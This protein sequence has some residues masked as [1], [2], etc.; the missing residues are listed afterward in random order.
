[1]VD[2]F[3]AAGDEA[4]LVRARAG[5]YPPPM[6]ELPAVPSPPF[7]IDRD[8]G[9]RA[10]YDAE[11]ILPTG[12]GGFAMGTGSGAP[13][14]KYHTLL[15]GA[16][17]PPVDRI[18]TIS[19]LHETVVLDTGTAR[20]RIVSLGAHV[21][22]GSEADDAAMP[23]LVRFEKERTTAR[24]T[25]EGRGVRLVKEL[26]VGWRRNVAAVRYRVTADRPGR[27][28]VTAWFAGR[29]FHDTRPTP[30]DH[31]LEFD[32]IPR[33]VEARGG[34][35]VVRAIADTARFDRRP[36]LAPL[37]CF[38]DLEH[39]RRLPD[40]DHLLAPGCFRLD[41]EAGKEATFTLAFALAPDEPDPALFDSDPRA[42][43]LGAL[44][45]RATRRDANLAGLEPL[46]GAADD[47]LVRRFV[48]DVPLMSVIAGYPWFADWGRD[49]MISLPGLMLTTGRF[50]DARS[51]LE[52]F[53]RHVSQGMI[54]NRFDDYGGPPHY[55]TVD[56]SLWF[57]HAATEYLGVTSDRAGFDRAMRAACIGIIEGYRRG[58]RY[59]IRMD[60][61]DGLIIAGDDT[62]QLTWMDAK[63]D[64][65]VFTPRHGKAVEINALWH[66][67][68]IAFAGA[69]GDSEAERAGEYRALA[70]RVGASFRERFVGGPGGGLHDCLRP[71]GAG[72]FVASGELRPNQIFAAS[73]EHSPLSAEQRRAVVACVRD[74]LL[75]PV[76]LRTLAAGDPGYQPRFDGDMIRRDRAYHNGT[77]WPWLIGA[78]AEAVLRVGGFSE[79]AREEAAGAIAGLIESMGSGC[80]GQICEVYDA[81]EPR[82]EEGCMAQAWSVAEVLRV[83]AMIGGGG[84]GRRF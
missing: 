65:I 21:A 36:G 32:E 13:R 18:A 4:P 50:E 38:Y 8:A 53:A 57:L 27:I 11:W 37:V 59:G 19:A 10:L 16:A 84:Q 5:S 48:D 79:A 31:P 25:Y 46:V 52:T 69:I 63:R 24:W 73:L 9:S 54:P 1:M 80:L 76:G 28:E 43:H 17:N 83:A 77:V 51:C 45:T 56:A 74:N 81:D 40:T 71:N 6:P 26:R 2:R 49:T 30:G 23:H 70:E 29:D 12:H 20:E 41:L 78:Y 44:T 55:N 47:F 39:A 75:T 15:N 34:S 67:G 66:H 60:G 35:H 3:G 7:A 22:P 61:D 68:L 64:G 33:G 58:T 72:G 62:T 14:R 82:R 42:D